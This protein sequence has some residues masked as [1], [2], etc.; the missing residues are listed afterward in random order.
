MKT[1]R[2]RKNYIKGHIETP[3]YLGNESVE[4]WKVNKLTM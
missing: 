2:M 1:G 3:G 4:A